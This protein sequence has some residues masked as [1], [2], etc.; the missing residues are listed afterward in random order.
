MP[1]CNLD[2]VRFLFKFLRLVA[3]NSEINQMTPVNLGTRSHH[4]C[5]LLL[6]LN[7]Y[8]A[9]MLTL[10]LCSTRTGIVFGPT[11][12]KAREADPLR[13]MTQETCGVVQFLIEQYQPIFEPRT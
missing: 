6:L 3:D 7:C 1:Q 8:S 5:P 2:V 11:L 4:Q 12:L 10:W 13:L 9:R